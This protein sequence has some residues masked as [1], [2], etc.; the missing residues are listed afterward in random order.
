MDSSMMG[1]D[2]R[3]WWRLSWLAFG[4]VVAVCLLVALGAGGGAAQTADEPPKSAGEF[5]DAFLELQGADAFGEYTEFETVRRVGVASTQVGDFTATDG[6]R[7]DAVYRM[8]TAFDQAYRHAEAGNYSRSLE[9][10]NRSAEAL[11][12]LQA[13]D[14]KYAPLAQ[15]ALDRFLRDEAGR[16]L[17]RAENADKTADQVRFLARSAEAYKL[18]GATGR[19]TEVSNREQEQRAELQEDVDVINTT[20]EDAEAFVGSCTACST[21]GEAVGLGPD[22]FTAYRA[23]FDL[24]GRLQDSTRRTNEH[25]LD[26]QRAQL[27]SLSSDIGGHQR[28]LAAASIVLVVTFLLGVGALTAV[29]SLRVTA[30][31]Q[32]ASQAGLGKSVLAEEVADA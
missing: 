1:D 18:A 7:M 28:A 17:E 13:A 11:D 4:T 10:A 20:I 26:A 3:P 22:T 31:H 24:D 27:Q 19:F 5:L 2:P 14:A 8:L 16:L 32:D 6:L 30:W 9:A 21:A 15:L 25:G 29:L 12:D 23:A